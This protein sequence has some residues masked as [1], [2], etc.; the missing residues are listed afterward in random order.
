MRLFKKKR[1]IT[2]AIFGFSNEETGIKLSEFYKKHTG[3]YLDFNAI[4]HYESGF[5]LLVFDL[6]LGEVTKIDICSANL[7]HAKKFHGSVEE[8][9]S[10]YE[11]DY[12]KG[13]KEV[14]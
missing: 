12:L 6:P 9:M 13:I 10:W 1:P 14:K 2:K 4:R 11:K 5:K 8:F 7:V 3:E